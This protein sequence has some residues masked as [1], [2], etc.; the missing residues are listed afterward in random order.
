MVQL[1][2]CTICVYHIFDEYPNAKFTINLIW[3]GIIS[4]IGILSVCLLEAAHTVVNITI[5]VSSKLNA[6]TIS[7]L[8][9]Q[10]GSNDITDERTHR[11]LKLVFMNI[12]YWDKYVTILAFVFSFINP[13]DNA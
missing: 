5:L 4:S 9:N 6:L 13:H 8:S 10:L 7:E 3:E 11:K 12:L 2:H 1:Q